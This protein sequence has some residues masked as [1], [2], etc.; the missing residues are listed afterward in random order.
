M[1]RFM[2]FLSKQAGGSANDTIL[3]EDEDYN[4]YDGYENEAF[5]LTEQQLTFDL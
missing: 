1:A 2:A 4:I 5:G 3:L